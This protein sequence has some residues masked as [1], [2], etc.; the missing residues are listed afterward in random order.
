MASADSG[1]P[2]SADALRLLDRARPQSTAGRAA[3]TARETGERKSA[4]FSHVKRWT[5]PQEPAGGSAAGGEA[6]PL[7]SSGSG[8][9]AVHDDT[10]VPAKRAPM[11]G[12]REMLAGATTLSSESKQI[13]ADR[14]VT[15]AVVCAAWVLMLQ[16][17]GGL[18]G[19]AFSYF[20]KDEL[21]V[22]PA[23]L[24]SI[25]SVTALP[26]VIK[27]LYA[28]PPCARITNARTRTC[29]DTRT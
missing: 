23:L 2:L 29:A 7:L 10:L 22:S 24:S 19:L 13:L 28:P 17:L 21:K 3:R 26:W 1:R 14:A 6:L 27:P 20:M 25:N 16:G 5:Q 9:H 8:V 4:R 15:M 18:Q 11:S 12:V